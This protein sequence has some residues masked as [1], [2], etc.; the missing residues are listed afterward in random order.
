MLKKFKRQTANVKLQSIV[1]ILLLF[2]TGVSFAEEFYY[3][4]DE[5]IV[6]ASRV[7]QKISDVPWSVTVVDHGQAKTYGAESVADVLRFVPGLDVYA[8]GG[9]GSLTSVRAR[10]ANATMVLVL[11]DGAKIN[12][13]LLG[14]VDF[15]TM[16]LANV[17]RIEVVPAPLSAV[18]G[19]SAVG[20]VVNIIT[21]KNAAGSP[22]DF[23]LSLGSYNANKAELSFGSDDYL[24]SAVYDKT[25]GFRANND[26]LGQTYSLT[27]QLQA[28]AGDLTLGLNY[29]KSD[30]GVPGVPNSADRFSASTPAN[31]QKDTNTNLFVEYRKDGLFSKIYQY[32]TAQDYH[33]YN[34]ATLAFSDYTYTTGQLGFNLQQDYYLNKDEVITLG[35]ERENEDGESSNIGQHDVNNTALYVNSEF[36]NQLLSMSLGLRSDSHSVVGNSFTPRF[37][38]SLHPQEDV[39][40]WFNLASAFRAPTLNELYWNDPIWSMY[41]DTTLKPEKAAGVEVGVEK[42][43]SDGSSVTLVLYAKQIVDQILWETDF[44]TFITQAKNVGKVDISGLD[45]KVSRKLADNCAIFGNA[46]IQTTIDQQDV[47]T[48]NVGNELPYSPKVKANVG[49]TWLGLSAIAKYVGERYSDAANTNKL[50]AYTVVDLNYRRPIKDGLE[51]FAKVSNLF[52]ARYSEA[53][54]WHPTTFAITEYP[55]PP[56]NFLFGAIITL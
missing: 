27:K 34:F 39:K 53:V 23:S 8:V 30:L 22:L 5:V 32:K 38:L 3:I 4:K 43:L 18:Y 44:T 40:C 55:M 29:Y 11:V 21:K 37:G 17:E 1:V 13:P 52:D 19:S 9:S 54:G 45:F 7:K 16:P 36:G 47:T 25:N 41:G 42:Y 51:L 50:A 31:R 46:T 2:L 56:R 28:L 12:S 48:A 15:S 35:F 33:E 49:A 26:Y 10:G 20:G 6:T 24:F 14:M